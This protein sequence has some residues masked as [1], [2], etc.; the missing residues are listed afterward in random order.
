MFSE[1]NL[2]RVSI[3]FSRPLAGES[4]G[5]GLIK[6]ALTSILSHKERKHE[7][8]RFVFC[9]QLGLSNE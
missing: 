6:R 8:D 4:E 7:G 3:L 1:N 5:E 9:Y 2:M